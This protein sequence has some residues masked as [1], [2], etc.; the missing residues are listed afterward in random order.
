MNI[1]FEY[2]RRLHYPNK[3]SCY[4]AFFTFDRDSALE[5]ILQQQLNYEFY[6]IC[7]IEYK[8]CEKHNLNLI[9]RCSHFDTIARAKYD[10]IGKKKKT[11]IRI[12]NQFMNI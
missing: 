10:W 6:K 4:Q 11:T 9:R 3:L 1:I 2:E 12:E 7:K 5:F 8:Y